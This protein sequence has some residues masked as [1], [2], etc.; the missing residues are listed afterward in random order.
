MTKLFFTFLLICP[1]I[2]AKHDFPISNFTMNLL[3]SIGMERITTDYITCHKD[4]NET[5]YSALYLPYN[6]TEH[7]VHAIIGTLTTILSDLYDINDTCQSS[8]KKIAHAFH[9]YQMSFKNESYPLAVV[10]KLLATSHIWIEYTTKLRSCIYYKSWGCA[11]SAT[12]KLGNHVFNV[13]PKGKVSEAELMN[14][15]DLIGF[16]EESVGNVLNVVYKSI[17]NFLVASDFIPV[18]NATEVCKANSRIFNNELIKALDMLSNKHNE[19]VRQLFYSFK[20]L[21]TMHLECKN[22][23]DIS[24]NT[25]NRYLDVILNLPDFLNRLVFRCKLL[26]SRGKAIIT[27]LL[28]GDYEVFGRHLGLFVKTLLGK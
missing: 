1:A 19:G 6:Y 28:K 24:V 11:G 21:K 13:T 14:I 18:V 26:T 17:V 20:P 10:K 3:S 4:V 9:L 22:V 8:A 12:G 2:F 15:K 7:K 27:T 16:D 25:F 23:I 5:L